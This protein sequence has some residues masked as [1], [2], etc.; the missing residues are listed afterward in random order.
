MKRTL[1][2]LLM[3][4]VLL[5]GFARAE[6]AAE[7]AGLA[8]DVVVLFTSDVH[9]GV[10][11]NFGYAGLQAVKDAC[12][13]AGNHVLLVDNGDSIQGEPLGT[14]T[15]GQA[16][17]ELMNAMGYDVAIP[18]NHEF[19]YGMDRFLELAEQAEFPY[20]SCNFNREGELVFDPYVIREFDGVKIAF[21]G[22]T[23]PKSLTTSTPSSFQDEAGNF[24]YGFFQD[25]TG[26]GVYAAVQK[27]VDDARAEGAEYVIVMGHMGNK[28]EAE[29]WTYADV[30]A[31]TTGIDA[32]LDGHSH[33]ADRVVMLNGAGEEVVRQ[34][35]GTKMAGIG[36]LKISKDDG[37]VDTGLYSWN[38]SVPAPELLGI[39]NEMTG[40]VED[41]TARLNETLGEVV[42]RTAVDLTIYDPE[43]VDANGLP[44]RIVRRAE[45][46]LG[47]LCADACLDQ[48][49]A[50]IAILNGGGIRV[51]LAKGDITR[52]DILSVH[53]FGNML[54]VIEATGQQVLDA[55]E[56]GAHALPNENGGFLQVAGLTYEIH[57]YIESSC[58]QDE[59]T[60]FAGVA[61]EYRVKNVKVN[62]EDLQPDKVYTLAS[63][64]YILLSN[65]DGYTM[66]DG[67]DVLQESVKLDNQVL[68]D[69]ITG[70]LGGVVGEEYAQPYGQGRI[71]AVE[72]APEA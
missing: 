39:A 28:A 25:T 4:I 26:E 9:C 29:P 48:S 49:G 61:G 27:A 16:I 43:A 14:M 47:D 32:F 42:A 35:C 40:A 70:T 60:M 44:V 38:N 59:N 54:T 24:I 1:A 22:V 30:I 63:L 55:L 50:D 18:G 6:D 12:E 19:D 20:I 71:I 46:N 64:D 34:A 45:T 57:T 37:S 51:S 52:S 2:L 62:G 23:T 36:W 3:L 67:C 5:T 13:A 33:D 17:I 11:Q 31:N 72:E 66:F 56:W 69:Y 65:G 58:V 15:K 41:A 21:V 10:D 8:Q 7:A 53:P 68:L